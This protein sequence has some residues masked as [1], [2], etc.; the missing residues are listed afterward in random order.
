[1]KIYFRT[2]NRSNS[3]AGA[4]EFFYAYYIKFAM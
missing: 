1:M 4:L 2:F 3:R